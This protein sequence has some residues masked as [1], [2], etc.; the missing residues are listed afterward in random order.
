M[1]MMMNWALAST[2]I[3]YPV[4]CHRNKRYLESLGC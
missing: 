2:H 4:N 1:I 3:L